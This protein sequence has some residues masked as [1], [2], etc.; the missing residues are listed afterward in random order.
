[1]KISNK[2]KAGIVAGALALSVLGA[3]AYFSAITEVK[4]NE[5]SI[6]AGEKDK[7]VTGAIVET[8]WD[9]EVAADPNYAKELQ[10]GETITKDPAVKN[11]TEY[12]AWVFV[13]VKVPALNA[14]KES[15]VED[16]VYDAV[17]P[18]FKDDG[19]GGKWKLI[20]STV[21]TSAG[22]DSEYTY[23]YTDIVESG[24]TT[25]TLF[26]TFTVQDFTKVDSAL[27]DSIDISGKM[28]QSVGYED[29]DSA[30]TALGLK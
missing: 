3:Y 21:S 2:I 18:E 11:V 10:P 12:D 15:D 1:M 23:G 8:E 25:E 24:A 13:T 22:T 27:E 30:A 4:N 16:K 26:D 6:V 29:L 14:R 5:F 17:V 7:N 28:I 19:H 9:R 20:K